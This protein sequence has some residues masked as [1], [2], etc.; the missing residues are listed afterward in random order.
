MCARS[1]KYLDEGNLVSY[2][3]ILKSE[4]LDQ[5]GGSALRA[6]HSAPLALSPANLDGNDASQAA[7]R[8][9]AKNPPGI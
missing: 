2:L 8:E 1:E 4:S 6:G 5:V 9:P 7:A 3:Q